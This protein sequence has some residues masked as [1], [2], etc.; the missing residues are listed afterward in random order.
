MTTTTAFRHSRKKLRDIA[1]GIDAMQEIKDYMEGCLTLDSR[2]ILSQQQINRRHLCR[3][4]MNRLDVM[5]KVGLA[6]A[7]IEGIDSIRCIETRYDSFG[8]VATVREPGSWET[9][10]VSVS[11]RLFPYSLEWLG[12]DTPTKGN[13]FID[14]YLKVYDPSRSWVS[15][16]QV[17]HS[18]VRAISLTPNY[19]RL[20]DWVREGLMYAPESAKIG[21]DR[22][23]NIWRLPS[24]VKAWK[25]C[26]DLPKHIAEKIGKRSPKFRILAAWAWETRDKWDKDNKE[27]SRAEQNADFWDRLDRI[28]RCPLLEQIQFLLPSMD[29]RRGQWIAFLTES[30]G[31]PWGV[32]ELKL[33]PRDSGFRD[34]MLEA[35]ALYADP[36]TA[37]KTL[38]GCTG[39]ATVKAFQ[40]STKEQWQWA[41][42][43]GESNPDAVQKILSQSVQIGYEPEAV[44]FLMSLPMQTRIK[45]LG[46]TTFKYRGDECIISPD[47]VRDTGYL[48]KNIQTKPELGRVRNWFS[49][50]ETLAAAFVKELPDEALPI[51]AGWDRLDGLCAVDGSWSIEFPKRVATLKYWGEIQ[52]NCVGGYGPAIKQGRS[53]VFV[54]RERGQITHTVEYSS[55][56]CNQFYSYGNGRPDHTVKESVTGAIAQAFS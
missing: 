3:W 21:G 10:S 56:V 49:V 43:V 32:I 30:L 29:W 31:L 55:G 41:A 50:H 27:I 36:S 7:D 25:W 20:P 11:Q 18:R 54:V 39:R 34:E 47:H 22:I 51:P 53:V 1:S 23:G 37:C 15:G 17:N 14:F 12:V 8:Y 13:R 28:A 45:L 52:R 2:P 35:I 46:C 38:F 16:C 9:K 40:G 24:C 19:N 42:A 48:W 44:D 6:C 4:M 5:H 33:N 26:P